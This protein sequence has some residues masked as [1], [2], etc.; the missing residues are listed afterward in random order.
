MPDPLSIW[1]EKKQFLET[2]LAITSDASQKFSLRKQIQDCDQEIA[3]LKN[4]TYSQGQFNQFN[5]ASSLPNQP[6]TSSSNSS[7]SPNSSNSSNLSDNSFN[8]KSQHRSTDTSIP[9]N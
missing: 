3:R 7:N 4:Q 8:E 5:H 9:I 6:S 2:A 1:I